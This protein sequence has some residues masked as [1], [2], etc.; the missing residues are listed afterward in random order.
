MNKV[1]EPVTI[2][3]TTRHEGHA[4]LVLNV[5]DEGIVTKAF[6][7]NTTPVRG[8][9][10]MLQGKT[11]AFG[12][13]AVMRICGICQA[14]HGIASCEAIE[15]AIDM[16]IPK[17]GMILRELLGLG[18]RMHSH[19]LHH[20]L[21]VDDFLK[22][23]E[24]GTLRV[25][26]IKLIQRMRKAGQM[27]V[28]VT[29]G[30]GIHPPNLM[31]GGM[32]TNITERAKSKLY[33][34]CREYEKDCNAM[35]EVLEMLM[36]RYLDEIGIP[37]LGKHN[38]PY[39]A[40][41]STFGNRDAIN[42]KDVT[43]V[44]A[45]RYYADFPDIAQTATNQI[46]FY[47]GN[48]AEG[49]PRARMIKYGN[50]KPAGGAMDLNLA[51]AMENFEAVKRSLELIDELNI[52]G[53]VRE[54]PNFYNAKEEFGIGVHEAPRAINTHMAKMGKDGR[55]EKYN[56]IAASTWNFPAVEKAIEGYHHQYAEVIMRA[57]DI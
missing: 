4:K 43:E 41:D 28:D 19:P 55:I 38:L 48:P 21:I 29:G 37:D 27:V 18:N 35:L 36:E 52:N 10:T 13:I 8:F 57:Y 47:R 1:A 51:R 11:A 34:A 50:F 3:P 42:F 33:Y 32:R 56:I 30:E 45:Q 22:P 31:V 39:I 49:G 9:E 16:E 7:P 6:Y 26:A 2:S 46:P 54:V 24:A 15:N 44:T 23:E 40:S 25:D 53:T 20:L 12:P 14:T 5:D 17:D